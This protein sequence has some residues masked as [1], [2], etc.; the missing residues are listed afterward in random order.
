VSKQDNP[1]YAIARIFSFI[2]PKKGQMECVF[3]NTDI[4]AIQ[5]KIVKDETTGL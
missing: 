5:L 2:T 3:I 4:T 1:V